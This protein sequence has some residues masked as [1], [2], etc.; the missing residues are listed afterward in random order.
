M[1]FCFAK[2]AESGFGFVETTTD[3]IGIVR[4]LRKT[5][6]GDDDSVETGVDE[7]SSEGFG[8]R[9]GIRRND[10]VETGFVCLLNHQRQVIVEEGFAL[11]IELDDECL[12]LHFVQRSFPNGTRHHW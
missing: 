7:L 9:L 1:S 11:K 8:K 2:E 10:G 3:A 5:V 6:H 12:L 4:L